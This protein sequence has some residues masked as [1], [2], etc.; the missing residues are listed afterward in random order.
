MNRKLLASAICASLLVAATAHAQ[1]NSASQQAQ[2]QSAP[3]QS[4][5]SSTDQNKKTLETVT[6][7]PPLSGTGQVP[8]VPPIGWLRFQPSIAKPV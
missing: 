7:T 8:A 1:D 3:A 4:T 5:Q 2:D 6:V